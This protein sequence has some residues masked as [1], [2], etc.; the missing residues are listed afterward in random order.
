MYARPATLV[1]VTGRAAAVVIVVPLRDT[2]GIPR[3]RRWRSDKDLCALPRLTLDRSGPW[4]YLPRRRATPGG[5]NATRACAQ[6][7]A[8]RRAMDS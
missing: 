4:C 2:I 6:P 3:R 1:R 7:A 8:G 5:P